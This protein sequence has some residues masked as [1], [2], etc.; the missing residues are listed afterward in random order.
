LEV[1]FVGSL[2]FRDSQWEF[3]TIRDP[4]AD[5]RMTSARGFRLFS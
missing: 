4:S 3:L 1:V 5:C 2:A